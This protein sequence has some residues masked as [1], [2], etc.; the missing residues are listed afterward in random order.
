MFQNITFFPSENHEKKNHK[1][2]TAINKHFYKILTKGVASFKNLKY[3]FLKLGYRR[4]YLGT[5]LP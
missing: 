1:N 3:K 5:F 4:S 2:H